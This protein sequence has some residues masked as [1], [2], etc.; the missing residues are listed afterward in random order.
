MWWNLVLLFNLDWS[1]TFF[2]RLI[3]SNNTV[4]IETAFC[5]TGTEHLSQLNLTLKA[6]NDLLWRISVV[7]NMKNCKTSF[8][9]GCS[10]RKWQNLAFHSCRRLSCSLPRTSPPLSSSPRFSIKELNA[11]NI[12]TSKTFIL[13]GI[14]KRKL[15]QGCQ[16][17]QTQQRLSCLCEQQQR[18]RRSSL[19]TQTCSGGRFKMFVPGVRLCFYG[20]T[21]THYQNDGPT[22][23]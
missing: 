12:M 14:F 11:S 10:V 13:M 17:Q 4:L 2:F 20:P 21:V 23:D 1:L 3:L 19:A 6:P 15:R 8:S 5:W 16:N 22:R 18:V 9:W 7:Y